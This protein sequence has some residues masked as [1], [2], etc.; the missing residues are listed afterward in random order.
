MLSG[1]GRRDRT[2]QHVPD[3]PSL[4]AE[5]PLPEVVR[6]YLSA[7]DNGDADV[8]VATFKPDGRVR[9]DGHDFV[10]SSEIRTWLTEASKR[11]VYTGT[12][13]S[14]MSLNPSVWVVVNRIE[15]NFPGGVVCPPVP[16]RARRR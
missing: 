1:Q 14:T 9:D 2:L 7:H 11:F 3:A 6:V 8:A 10:G 13:V 5:V 4:H 15:D 12:L 16:V